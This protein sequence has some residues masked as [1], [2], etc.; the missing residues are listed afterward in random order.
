MMT[1]LVSHMVSM[2]LHAPPKFNSTTTVVYSLLNFRSN[3]L[4]L[5]DC[6]VVDNVGDFFHL[7][8][9]SNA[10]YMVGLF[11]CLLISRVG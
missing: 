10:V 6:F 7:H 8:I 9:L 4:E 2:V 3:F 11:R 1:N 5:V